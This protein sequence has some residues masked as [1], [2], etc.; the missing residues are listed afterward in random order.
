LNELEPLADGTRLNVHHGT[1]HTLARL[2]R[3][4]DGYAQLRLAEPVVAA[5]GDRV[6]LRT[7]TTVGGGVVLDPAPPRNVDVSRLDLLESGDAPA[8]VRATV[9]APV[10]GPTLQ[11]HALL[12]P[13]ELALGLASARSAGDW[14]FSDEWLRELKARVRD[15]LRQRAEHA[16]LDP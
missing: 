16:P 7:D 10:T 2:V 11:A 8:I 12:P 3:A 15:R 4:G 1:S 5:R 9:Y 6:V 13:R 14:Y